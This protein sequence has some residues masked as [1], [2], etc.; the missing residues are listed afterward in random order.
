[1]KLFKITIFIIILFTVYTMA[2]QAKENLSDDVTVEKFSD[3]IWLYTAYYDL[4]DFKHCPANGL[5]VI[6]RPHAIMINVPWTDEQTAILFDWVERELK[7]TV[8]KVIPT[9]SHGDCAGG[10]AEARRR[11][12]EAFAL[13]KTA[14]LLED[15]GHTVPENY[16]TDTLSLAC[17]SIRVEL[18]YPGAGHTVDNIVAWIPQEKILFGGC[19]IKSA[20]ATSPGH[21]AD[22]SLEEWPKSL[23]KVREKYSSAEIVIPG[24]GNPGVLDLIEHTLKLLGEDK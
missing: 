3:G 14:K 18:F 17:G 13:D 8:D 6:D 23:M 20:D 5:I 7:G 1:M 4:P 9:H 24:H 22:A 19:L 21:I 12:A 16:F 10:L 2:V 11:K 15:T